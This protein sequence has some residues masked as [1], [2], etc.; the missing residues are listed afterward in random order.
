MKRSILL[1]VIVMII[2]F[3]SACGNPGSSSEA[4]ENKTQEENSTVA[5][6][7][8][9]SQTE[10]TQ[11]EETYETVQETT[12]DC[13]RLIEANRSEL[14]HSW[15]QKEKSSGDTSES[16]IFNSDGTGSYKGVDNKNYTFTYKI[17]ITPSKD[18][19]YEAD[20]KIIIKYNEIDDSET[21]DFH[22]SEFG[23]LY[24]NFSDHNVIA[25]DKYVTDDLTGMVRIED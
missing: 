18:D 15:T 11:V 19:A 23:V 6:T 12:L 7:N 13:E 5:Q 10:S 21:R 20:Q 16:L 14:V 25:F 17:S 2:V 24:L 4:E 1:F 9:S 22:F 8:D 3:L